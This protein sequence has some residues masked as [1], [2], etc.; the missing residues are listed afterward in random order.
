MSNAIDLPDFE[1]TVA[2][3]HRSGF[4]NWDRF[5][6][7][8]RNQS[9][10]S[11]VDGVPWSFTYN[12]CP[13]TH[14]HYE[15][16]LIT[17]GGRTLRFGFG[18]LL[19]TMPD[20]T[21]VVLPQGQVPEDGGWF[22]PKRAVTDG[23]QDKLNELIHRAKWGG[24]CDV[25]L[26]AHGEDVT[27]EADWVKYLVPVAEAPVAERAAALEHLR[28]LVDNI[29]HDFQLTYG[30]YLTDLSE[31]AR[32]KLSK[33]DTDALKARLFLNGQSEEGS[34]AWVARLGMA[35][36]KFHEPS[37]INRVSNTEQDEIIKRLMTN[38]GQP[39][40][41]SLYQ[42]FKQFANEICHGHESLLSIVQ[43]AAQQQNTSVPDVMAPV[44]HDLKGNPIHS[45]LAKSIAARPVPIPGINTQEPLTPHQLQQKEAGKFQ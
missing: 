16:Y 9:G 38:L 37:V 25:K 32:T 8:G 40:S 43:R 29:D 44:D 24:D 4:V 22:L 27:F 13:V 35:A 17:Q 42:A 36:S 2:P 5:L 45:D 11:V 1:V 33:L 20:G 39:D 19:V 26:R 14:E 10:A 15:L 30:A 3:S 34:Q 21:L 41:H 23:V 28:T 31:D 12:G 6:M 7:I 18:D